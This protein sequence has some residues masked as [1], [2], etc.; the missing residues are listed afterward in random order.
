MVP[1]QN[2]STWYGVKLNISGCVESLIMPSNKLNGSLPPEIGDLKSLKILNLTNNNISGNLPVQMGALTSLVELNLTTN[3]INGPLPQGFGNMSNLVKLQLSL[4]N[5][6]GNIPASLGNLS[7]MVILHLHQNNF[8]G[9]IPPS[10]GSLNNLEELLHSQNNLTG[11]IPSELGNMTNLKSLILS[12]NKL[13][14][15]L[16]NTLGRLMNLFS[17][18]A[19]ENQLSGILPVE[20]GNLTDLRELWL[21]KNIFNGNIPDEL[22][23]CTKLQKLL[24]N[25]NM[26]TGNIPTSI[27]NLINL[28]SL[29]LSNNNLSGSIPESIS[30]LNNLISL[31]VGFN[32]LSGAIPTSFGNLKSLINLNLQNNNLTGEI[33]ENFGALINVKRLYCQENKL[34]GFP[35]SML[36]FCPLSEST[37]VSSTGYNFRGNTNLIFG[38]DFKRWCAGDGR[39]NAVIVANS[40]LCEGSSLNLTATGG[41][42][43]SWSGP[44]GFIS[45]IQNPTISNINS[46]QFGM[47]KVNVVNEFK[48]RDTASIT[49]KSI[50]TV[51]ASSNSPICE[52]VSIVLNATGGLTY[53]WGGQWFSSLIQNP[54]ILNSNPSMAGIYTVEINTSDC[55]IK[56]EIEIRFL[57]FGTI[58]S[59]SPICEGDTL[60]LSVS[61]GKSFLWTGPDGFKNN[62]KSPSIIPTTLSKTGRYTAL[63]ES[64]NGCSYSLSTEVE[65]KK[66]YVP[67]LT[68][69]VQEICQ[70]G[71]VVSLPENVDGF[72]GQWLG[73]G[74]KVINGTNYFIPDSL[75]GLQLLTFLPKED[76]RCVSPLEQNIYVSYIDISASENK[77]SLNDQNNNGSIII[78]TSANTPE[79]LITRLFQAN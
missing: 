47:Y 6:S 46:A 68:D 32:Q 13:S 20:L 40:P 21:N 63:V 24:L 16:P 7:E 66:N 57:V 42:A 65:I 23:N 25:D 52:G 28:V 35:N 8:N 34:E 79:I 5:F 54:V 74:I 59:N 39:A 22:T 11:N 64:E 44:S 41:V 73:N 31:L 9:P 14:G 62:T 12:Q 27:G 10:L 56:K 51:S 43:Y 37:N 15:T 72:D 58:S 19:D 70:S 38:G 61:E 30:N 1:G 55:T 2:I 26:L 76:G 33:P 49:I 48:C 3:K 60:R 71:E 69:F 17:F 75:K 18:Y 78:T 67:V 50:S 36:I 77:P 45:D 53:K 4:N 29:H